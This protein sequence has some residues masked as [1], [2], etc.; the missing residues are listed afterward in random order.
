MIDIV[1][2]DSACGSLKMAQHY[3]IGKFTSSIEVFVTSGDG[4]EPAEEEIIV[5]QREAEERERLE[6]D[7]ATPMGGNPADVYGFAYG[8]SI[9]DISESIPGEKRRQTLEWLYSIHPYLDDEPAFTVELMQRATD[10]LNEV[11]ARIQAGESVRI[12][13]SSQ[14][15][16][17]CGMYWFVAHLNQLNIPSSQIILIQLPEWE[18]VGGGTVKTQS[19]W[20]GI[21]PGEWHSHLSLQR[22]APPMFCEFCASHWS[23]LQQE[24]AQLRAFLNGRLVSVPESIYDEFIVRE[25]SAEADEF[26]EAMII[27]RVLGKYELGIGD[28]LVAHRIE[29][30]IADGRLTPIS[31]PPKGSPIYHRR[32]KKCIEI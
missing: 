10:T 21:K 2:G 12:W 5:A 19:G 31:E 6:W 18:C 4:S 23:Y 27:G 16:E 7:N 20:G 26:H 1:F 13:Y 14:P 32:L 25:I 17:I 9:G 30:M 15:D 11:S 3:G 22:A 28:A 8:L 29:T 24:N